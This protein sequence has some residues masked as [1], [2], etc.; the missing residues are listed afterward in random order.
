MKKVYISFLLLLFVSLAHAQQQRDR[1]GVDMQLQ[2]YKVSERLLPFNRGADFAGYRTKTFRRD[3]RSWFSFGSINI[4]N[5]IL[6]IDGIPLYKKDKHRSVD[7]FSFS[8]VADSGVVAKTECRAIFRK[9]ETFSLF[10]PKDSSFF[11]IKNVDFLQA[12]IMVD[13][14][15]SNIWYMAAANLNGSENDEQ[16]G[17]IRCGEKEIRFAKATRMLRDEPVG[18]DKVSSLFTSLNIVYEFTYKDEVIGAVSFKQS[19]RK[20]WCKDDLDATLK[21]VM[22]SVSTVLCL[23]NDLFY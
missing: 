1:V 13:A 17:I 16:S 12:R 10:R 6:K 18:R 23:R 14:D 3:I 7:I 2:P 20:F 22:A 21:K 19:G 5:E 4:E 9:N 11:K 15:T 8:L